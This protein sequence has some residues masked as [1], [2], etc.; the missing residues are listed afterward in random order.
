MISAYLILMIVALLCFLCAAIGR[1]ATSPFQI[2]WLGALTQ[3]CCYCSLASSR[4]SH[5]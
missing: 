4:H 1:P 3:S 5:Y 2:G